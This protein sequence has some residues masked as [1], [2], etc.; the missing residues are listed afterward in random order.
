M[1]PPG[2]RRRRITLEQAKRMAAQGRHPDGTP[3]MPDQMCIEC[4]YAMNAATPTKAS[5]TKP[6]DVPKPGDVSLC[7]NC[8]KLQMFDDKMRFREPTPHEWADPELIDM[9]AKARRAITS[10]RYQNHGPWVR[11]TT[12]KSG[13]A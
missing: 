9:Q 5:G 1:P 12:E 2:V 10:M 11:A 6:D 7:L 8:G 4:G 3:K 13:K